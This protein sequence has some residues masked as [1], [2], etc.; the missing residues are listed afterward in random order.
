MIIVRITAGL[1]NQMFQY[2]LAKRYEL[3][4]HRVFLD[5]NVYN[6]DEYGTSLR[7]YELNSFCISIPLL[8]PQ[9]HSFFYSRNLLWR[10]FRRSL[11]PCYKEIR[12]KNLAY[13]PRYTQLKGNAVLN[14][15]FQSERYFKEIGEGLRKDFVFKNQLSPD[16][17]KYLAKIQHCNSVSIHIRRGDYVTD[18]KANRE[19]GF[20]SSSFY[21]KAVEIIKKNVQNPIFFIFSDDVEWVQANPD[22][23][24]INDVIW[25]SGN[26]GRNAWQDM[27]LMSQC[28]HNIIANSSFSW[29]SAWLNQN[30][31]KIVIAP[32]KWYADESFNAETTDLIPADWLRI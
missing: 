7:K 22:F 13:H 27:F 15:Y 20:L 26:A 3:T 31:R 17:Q 6:D 19:L 23:L 1:G 29:W 2:A 5:T 9:L 10:C 14:G 24:N 12:E 25:V 4:G 11:T 32:Q 30:E 18:P 21:Q 16:A 28:K 8:P